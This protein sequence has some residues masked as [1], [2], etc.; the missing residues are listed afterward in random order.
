MESLAGATD[1]EET[2]QVS[3]KHV[4]ADLKGDRLNFCML[5]ALYILQGFPMGLTTTIPIILQSRNMANYEQQVSF[6]VATFNNLDTVPTRN[7]V[8]V[9]LFV[10][11]SRRVKYIWTI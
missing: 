10:L 6:D 8:H 4:K 5:L 11:Q 3:D 9:Q 1:H 7:T 2:F